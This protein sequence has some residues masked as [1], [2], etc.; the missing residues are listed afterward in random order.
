MI[1][2]DSSSRHHLAETRSPL[3]NRTHLASGD[4]SNLEY[5][6]GLAD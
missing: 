6:S 2:L 3:L 4:I 5:I 1:P